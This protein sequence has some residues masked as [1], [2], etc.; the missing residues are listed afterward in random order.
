MSTP[1]AYSGR[2]HLPAASPA[3]GDR[4]HPTF[5][6]TDLTDVHPVTEPS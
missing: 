2:E 4:W 6:D 1:T 5:R 3:L